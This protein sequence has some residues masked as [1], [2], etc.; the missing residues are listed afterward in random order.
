MRPK[1]QSIVYSRPEK[2]NHFNTV[3]YEIEMLEFC[4]ETLVTNVGKWGDMRKAFIALGRNSVFQLRL[5]KL[6]R[7]IQWQNR[8]SHHTPATE[9]ASHCPRR[10]NIRTHLCVQE[11]AITH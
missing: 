8:M 7:K 2:G 6:R 9:I 10:T 3:L 4:Y 11:T 5:P 1:D